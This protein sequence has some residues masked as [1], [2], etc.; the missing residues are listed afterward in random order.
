MD[1]LTTILRLLRPK[2]TPIAFQPLDL[3]EICQKQLALIATSHKQALDLVGLLQEIAFSTSQTHQNYTDT[4][5][6]RASRAL[7]T[8]LDSLSM[9]SLNLYGTSERAKELISLCRAAQNERQQIPPQMIT[10]YSNDIS[11]NREGFRAH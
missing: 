9:H 1:I 5:R 8:L 11:L 2:L 6:H 7:N 10:E 3:A 4:D